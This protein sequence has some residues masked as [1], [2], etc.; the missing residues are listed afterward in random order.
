LPSSN[1]QKFAITA[2]TKIG[3]KVDNPQNYPFKYVLK[4]EQGNIITTKTIY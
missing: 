3:I 1:Q 4:D 2:K